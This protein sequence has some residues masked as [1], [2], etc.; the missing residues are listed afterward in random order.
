MYKY[1]YFIDRYN[2]AVDYLLVQTY[3]LHKFMIYVFSL[4]AVFVIYKNSFL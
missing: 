4:V 3:P 2:V 1:I